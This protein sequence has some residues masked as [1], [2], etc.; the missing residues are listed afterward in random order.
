MVRVA[1]PICA[2][3]SL[4]T[5]ITEA[6]LDLRA[7]DLVTEGTDDCVNAVLFVAARVVVMELANVIVPARA[8]ARELVTLLVP[9]SALVAL[10][11]RLAVASDDRVT[12]SALTK[13]DLLELVVEDATENEAGFPEP[14][15]S[16]DED[17]EENEERLVESRFNEVEDASL[18][19]NALAIARATVFKVACEKAECLPEVRS[20]ASDDVAVIVRVFGV[21][22]AAA[23]GARSAGTYSWYT[24]RHAS[25]R[26]RNRTISASNTLQRKVPSSAKYDRRTKRYG[27]V[28]SLC[29]V[30]GGEQQRALR[31]CG[32]RLFID[33]QLVAIAKCQRRKVEHSLK[34]AN[35]GL[36]RNCRR[37]ISQRKLGSP[38]TV[39]SSERSDGECHQ[40]KPKMPY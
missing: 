40:Y 7:A 25:N 22:T 23:D 3:A 35:T 13:S 5:D 8:I 2:A 15:L 39:G 26:P 1:P 18:N 17:A 20:A 19:V 31:I 21:L 29:V 11:A 27:A 30:E 38:S 9:V 24:L 10:A 4:A 6:K 34:C 14:L 12:I 28:R 32:S 16:V 37:R 36:R 33:T